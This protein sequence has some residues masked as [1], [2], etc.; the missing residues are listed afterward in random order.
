MEMDIQ[1]ALEAAYGLRGELMD[2]NI[3]IDDL[4]GIDRSE[5][6]D[7]HAARSVLGDVY[8]VITEYDYSGYTI[9]HIRGFCMEP[10]YSIYLDDDEGCE[11]MHN[12]ICHI[13]NLPSFSKQTILMFD[14]SHNIV[15]SSAVAQVHRQGNDYRILDENGHL[16]VARPIDDRDENLFTTA[17]V[18]FRYVVV[19]EPE[20]NGRYHVIQNT[21]SKYVHL[22]D[23]DDN[24][25]RSRN[26]LITQLPVSIPS[27]YN[28]NTDSVHPTTRIDVGGEGY[29]LYDGQIL[30]RRDMA[31]H[32]FVVV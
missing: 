4:E 2:D 9:R 5:G 32:L 22:A 8:T 1:E 25:D 30:R 13:E 27:I 26:Y 31:Y 6:L 24:L 17:P 18:V 16:T 19:V 28:R 23:P 29:Y 7:R 15:Y 21:R 10:S 12:Y 20:L 3:Y 14:E 11:P